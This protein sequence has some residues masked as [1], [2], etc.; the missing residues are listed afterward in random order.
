MQVGDYGGIIRVTI[1]ED[2]AVKNISTATT[3]QFRFIRPDNVELP[4]VTAVFTTDG[5][6][7]KLQF[8]VTQG[9]LSKHGPWKIQALLTYA[10]SYQQSKIDTFPVEK[11]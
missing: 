3:K 4:A 9:M 2:G 7:G 6:D 8:T 10:S 5:S 1:K 11:N